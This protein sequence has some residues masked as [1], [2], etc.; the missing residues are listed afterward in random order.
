MFSNADEDAKA[1]DGAQMPIE[2]AAAQ[3]ITTLASC[4]D[5]AAY[6]LEMVSRQLSN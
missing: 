2:I 3:E 6:F 1:D 4:R 5:S